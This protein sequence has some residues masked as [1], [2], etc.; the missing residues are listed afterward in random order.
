[1]SARRHTALRVTPA[2]AAR[3]SPVRAAAPYGVILAAPA[4]AAAAGLVSGRPAAALASA[5]PAG[6]DRTR[7]D[8]P[9]R[10]RGR[11][12]AAAAAGTP[13]RR[14]RCAGR[15]ARRCARRA[16]RHRLRQPALPRRRAR[17]RRAPPA[18]DP[19]PLRDRAMN[20]LEAV[21]LMVVC[22]AA[23]FGVIAGLERL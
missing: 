17:G 19:D 8:R 15:R 23:M 13:P 2:H 11:V 14:P 3:P 12:G 1:M 20:D 18:T 16:A 6:H 10:R 9:A 7:T 4:I 22:M 5:R 21:L